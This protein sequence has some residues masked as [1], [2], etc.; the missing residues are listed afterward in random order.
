MTRKS[1]D[2]RLERL[3]VMVPWIST[4]DGPTV[5]EVCERFSITPS[6]LASDLEMLF[7][8]GLYPFTPDTLI[9][10]DMVDGRVWIR[11]ADTFQRPPAFTSEEAVSLVA[12]ASAVLDLPNVQ[13]SQRTHL[14]SAL[15]KLGR[16]LNLDDQDA[17][18]V[19]LSPTSGTVLD[20]I[21]SAIDS[22]SAISVTYYSH[23]R[24]A[25]TER[26]LEPYQLF[27]A[28]GQW[29]LQARAPEVDE[30]RTFR[31]DR[32]RKL[33]VT[34]QGFEKPIPLPETKVFQ[35]RDED[36]LLVLEL[37]PRAISRCDSES[38]S[39]HGPSD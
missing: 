26:F 37:D 36:P 24:D 33:E 3:L 6:E 7:M 31:V 21:R 35:A 17:V 32:M 10:A 28:D 2:K 13:D 11:Y 5:D 18:D 12:A 23:G 19:D 34:E 14:E 20:V 25:W 1:A 15:D 30:I 8:C 4:E 27:N 22:S 16:A 39:R 29:Y 38:V 9:E